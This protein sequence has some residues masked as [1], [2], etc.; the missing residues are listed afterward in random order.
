MRSRPLESIQPRVGTTL[1]AGASHASGVAAFIAIC[2]LALGAQ[3]LLSESARAA[4]PSIAVPGPGC[5]VFNPE[6]PELCGVI[7]LPG[8]GNVH[9]Y[10]ELGLSEDYGTQVP[11]PPGTELDISSDGPPVLVTAPLDPGDLQPDT[12]Y[13]YRLAVLDSEGVRYYGE[14]AT[15]TTPE[16]P[17]GGL[18]EM[19][20]TEACPGPI[21]GSGQRLCGTLN[22]GSSAK[23]GYYF[24]VSEGSSCIGGTHFGGSSEVEGQNVAVS[25]EVHGLTPNTRYAVCLVA[26]NTTGL[27]RGLGLTF[28][29]PGS[30]QVA[31]GVLPC[32]SFNP[33]HPELC[34]VISL[35][36]GGNIHYYFELGLSEDYG[37]QVP[38]PPGTELDISADGPPVLA[39]APLAPGDLQPDTTY[40][41]RLAVLDSEGIRYYGEPATFTTPEAPAVGPGEVKIETPIKGAI[42]PFQ[43]PSLI[44]GRVPPEPP[45]KA[46]KL[47]KALKKCRAKPRHRAE[48]ER[49]V[50]RKLSATSTRKKAG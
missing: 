31:T 22:P 33:E 48:C 30:L 16:A 49:Q 46:Q 15:F 23:V 2:V 19:P 32:A 29:T 38:N 11:N 36:G 10:F 26:T 5:P 4:E 45:P 1:P 40:F 14:P 25:T 37:T 50:R 12:T 3:F 7:S 8:G 39:T 42:S 43:A 13:F 41:Y 27:T 6:H 21:V 35:P 34:G 44:D 28:V 9:Y 17:A 20:I 18:P 24:E 47:A